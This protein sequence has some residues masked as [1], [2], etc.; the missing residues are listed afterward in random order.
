MRASRLIFAAVLLLT[1]VAL[2]G[3]RIDQI[4]T[5][6]PGEKMVYCTFIGDPPIKHDKKINAPGRYR[7]DGNGADSIKFTVR[8]QREHGLNWTTVKSQTWTIKGEN[9]TRARTEH[10]RTRIVQIGC[11]KHVYRTFVHVIEHSRGYTKT[12]DYH[13]VGVTNPCQKYRSM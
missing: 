3:C 10:T 13:S 9:T 4:D 2:S 12:F 8:I 5:T 11:A 7:C 6:L 1:A